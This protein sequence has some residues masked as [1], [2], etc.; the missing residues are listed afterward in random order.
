MPATVRLACA[1][2]VILVTLGSPASAEEKSTK[3]RIAVL[4]F[5]DKAAAEIAI[6]SAQWGEWIADVERPQAAG[7]W[8]KADGLAVSWDVP[9][10]SAGKSTPPTV[11]L[12]RGSDSA[13]TA[14][15]ANDRLRNAGPKD[16]G[17][18][19]GRGID[20]A[21]VDGEIVN[22]SS[23]A[24]KKP[25]TRTLGLAP[26]SS[27]PRPAA[28]G[29]KGGTE[30]INI[31]VGELQEATVSKSMDSASPKLT[32]QATIGSAPL[33]RGSVM[34]RLAQPWA[35]CAAGDR[36]NGVYL[37]TG[38]T[39]KYRLDGA[40]IVACGPSTVTINYTKFAAA[41]EPVR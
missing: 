12:K 8:S 40:R 41:G 1:A 13:A 7:G 9:E 38:V 6:E 27:K 24:G 4:E 26:G 22:P 30:D 33:E 19:A 20:I 28:S 32:Q 25:T 39:H 35:G 23:T 10:A 37:T 31:G 11:T 34:L 21:A 5:K 18:S 14:G 15:R 2:S 36:F 3:P 17:L 16:G 29:E